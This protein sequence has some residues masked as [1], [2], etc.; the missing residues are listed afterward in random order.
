MQKNILG[1]GKKQCRCQKV[2]MRMVPYRIRRR[3]VHRAGSAS[4]CQ[5]SQALQTRPQ[6]QVGEAAGTHG[7][8]EVIIIQGNLY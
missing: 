4:M 2:E 6:P 7:C 1:Q 3:P 5:L 8:A